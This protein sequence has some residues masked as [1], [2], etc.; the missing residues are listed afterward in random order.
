MRPMGDEL[1]VPGRNLD[2]YALNSTSSVWERYWSPA[3][4]GTPPT[5]AAAFCRSGPLILR[6][7]IGCQDATPDA[8]C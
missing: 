1:G 4:A 5:M 2:S 7:V 3:P 8:R 6:V